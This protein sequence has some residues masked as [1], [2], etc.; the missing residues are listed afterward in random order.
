MDQVYLLCLCIPSYCLLQWCCQSYPTL[1]SGRSQH[2]SSQQS[3]GVQTALDPG[4]KRSRS[5]LLLPCY[6]EV[7]CWGTS[8]TAD[9]I[10]SLLCSRASRQSQ[11]SFLQ[12]LCNGPWSQAHRPRL[13]ET[14][15]DTTEGHDKMYLVGLVVQPVSQS[16]TKH[17]PT[18]RGSHRLYTV[19]CPLLARHCRNPMCRSRSTGTL[20]VTLLSSLVTLVTS[21][22]LL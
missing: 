4:W 18:S 7:C 20:N 14:V 22:S 15:M 13:M 12:C 19:V 10:P 21:T 5:V 9:E 6:P 2:F 16:Q 8:D 3:A 17:I 11:R 1:H